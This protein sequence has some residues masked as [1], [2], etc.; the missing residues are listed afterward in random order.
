[1]TI[2]YTARPSLLLFAGDL[3]ANDVALNFEDTNAN[4]YPN[5]TASAQT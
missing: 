5:V 3:V 2:E 4:M 1:M